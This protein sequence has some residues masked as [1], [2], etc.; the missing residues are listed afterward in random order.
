MVNPSSYAAFTTVVLLMQFALLLG[1]S[2]V[3]RLPRWTQW[4]NVAL[5][6]MATIMTLS[7]SAWLG[8]LGG[9]LALMTF[10]KFRAGLRVAIYSAIVGCGIILSVYSY[11]ASE[12]L[13][14]LF[15]R[16]A[17]NQRTLD[18]RMDSNSFAIDKLLANPSNVLTGIGVGTFLVEFEQL[19]GQPLIIHNTYLWLLVE[20][21]I[22]GFI[23]GVLVLAISFRQ[24]IHVARANTP[25]SAIATGVVCAMAATL[26]WFLGTEGLWHRHVWFLFILSEVCYRLCMTEASGD[27]DSISNKSRI[28][29]RELAGEVVVKQFSRQ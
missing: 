5:L 24:A 1:K 17:L 23:L 7:R 12:D 11:G 28:R 19:R 2:K 9:L 13:P 15:E 18:Q 16:T 4:A 29:V 25:E 20:T 26:I 22:L 8:T 3:V 21:G 14:V 27:R 10:Y 6:G